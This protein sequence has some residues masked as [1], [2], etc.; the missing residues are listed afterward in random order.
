[1]SNELAV[2]AY[3]I[4]DMERMAEAFA[5]S[6]LFGVKTVDQAL[7]LM[8]LSQA[9]GLHPATAARDYHIIQGRPALKADAIL[10]RFQHAGGRLEWLAYTDA[11]V[12]ARFSHPQGGTVEID[13][14]IE[15]ARTAGLGS[16]DN[17]KSYPRQMLR[18]RVISEGVRTVYPAVLAG[19]YTPEE[20]MDFDKLPET[21]PT[22]TAA[23]EPALEAESVEL[24]TDKQ[25]AAIAIALKKAGF[26]GGNEGAKTRGRSF[27][28]YLAGLEHLESI[29]DLTKVEAV[30]ILDKIGG[31]VEGKYRADDGKLE[32]AVN[33]WTALMAQSH[34]PVPTEPADFASL[35]RE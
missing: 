26:E 14:D 5:R 23:T 3:S 21:A 9:E 34:A 8:L 7:A 18:A 24:I 29:D 12:A 27:V 13:W 17:W 30:A 15:R 32:A 1:M 31:I 4:G 25:K 19:M 2:P 16:K 22:E 20:V 28:A 11:K 35:G 33:E 6:N 10:A